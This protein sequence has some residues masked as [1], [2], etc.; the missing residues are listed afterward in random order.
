MPVFALG[1]ENPF[2]QRLPTQRQQPTLTRASKH[3]G[4]ALIE[5]SLGS[6]II[7][8]RS[9]RS[10]QEPRACQKVGEIL[11]TFEQ[12]IASGRCRNRTDNFFA[13]CADCPIN[14]RISVI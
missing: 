12:A 10:S 8:E 1:P 5:L 6:E 2:N 7:N 3:L 9:A 14:M 11:V 13:E 4:Y